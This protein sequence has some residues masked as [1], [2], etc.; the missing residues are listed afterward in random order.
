MKTMEAPSASV[1]AAPQ[2]SRA[3]VAMTR[4]LALFLGSYA[5][6]ACWTLFYNFSFIAVATACVLGC[7]AVGLWLMRPWSRWIVYSLSAVV[8]VWFAWYVSR[9]MRD[10]WP[11]DDAAKSVVAVLPASLLFLGGIAAAA[12]V[13]RVLPPR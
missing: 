12:L 3:G 13:A 7:A 2:L 5:L 4:A 10:G 11:Y 6:F 1:A 9:L 8:C